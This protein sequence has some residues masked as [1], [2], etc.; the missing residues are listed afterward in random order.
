[1]KIDDIISKID[2]KLDKGNN[3]FFS[4]LLNYLKSGYVNILGDVRISDFYVS[5]EFHSVTF[6]KKNDYL[7]IE[8]HKDRLEVKI[9]DFF[10]LL[11]RD[12]YPKEVI[13]SFIDSCFNGEYSLKI[14]R[15]EKDK[16]L[17]SKIDWND[18]KL[19]VFNREERN[20]LIKGKVELE[21]ILSGTKYLSR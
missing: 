7:N 13:Y 8:L 19:S 5:S 6:L 16:V 1:M 14:Y 17:S 20:T 15:N 11:F 3:S 18:T 12:D 10:Y 2:S 21:N 4:E 9:N